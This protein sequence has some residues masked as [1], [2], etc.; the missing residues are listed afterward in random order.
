[1]H[2]SRL[3][4]INL[5]NIDKFHVPPPS[6]LQDCDTKK[7]TAKVIEYMQQKLAEKQGAYRYKKMNHCS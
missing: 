5:D 7:G 3:E 4:E 1:V 6:V 2:L